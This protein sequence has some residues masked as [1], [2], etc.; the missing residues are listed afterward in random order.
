MNLVK[1]AGQ[2]TE[3]TIDDETVVMSL[4]SGEFFSLTGTSRAIWQALDA[5]QDR[6]ALITALAADYG[7]EASMIAEDV[8]TFLAQLAAAGLLTQA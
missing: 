3:T 7:A 5:H 4:A 8:D 2:F 6:L 1:A